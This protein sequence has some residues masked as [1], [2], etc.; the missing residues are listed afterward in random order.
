MMTIDTD[1]PREFIT[2][3]YSSFLSPPE[4]RIYRVVA[5]THDGEELLRLTGRMAEVKAKAIVL[6]LNG[7]MGR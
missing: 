6:I 5:G 3:N 1:D 4:W 2:M 7:T